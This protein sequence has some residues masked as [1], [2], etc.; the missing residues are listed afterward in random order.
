MRSGAMI[1][2]SNIKHT[3]MSH[4]AFCAV[5]TCRMHMSV[6]SASWIGTYCR[7]NTCP[8]LWEDHEIRKEETSS[9]QPRFHHPTEQSKRNWICARCCRLDFVFCLSKKCL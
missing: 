1:K 3:V 4:M 9:V 8:I 2:S 6:W 5:K 7:A